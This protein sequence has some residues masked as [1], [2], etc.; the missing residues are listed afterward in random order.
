MFEG[1]CAT[2]QADATDGVEVPRGKGI[3]ETGGLVCAWTACSILALDSWTALCHHTY[4]A[5]WGEPWS[6]F[7]PY[8]GSAGD[9]YTLVAGGVGVFEGGA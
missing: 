8:W 2:R 6:K 5:L 3:R 1:S 9:R 7:E 4:S